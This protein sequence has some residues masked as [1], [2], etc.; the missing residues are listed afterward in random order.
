MAL[1]DRLNKLRTEQNFT[2]KEVARRIGVSQPTINNWEKGHTVPHA[3]QLEKLA[4]LYK[5]T[6][7]YLMYGRSRNTLRHIMW[8]V[9]LLSWVQAG[10][11]TEADM[12]F[13][14]N[15]TIHVKNKPSE[16]TFA[17][18]VKG[19][20]MS[21]RF[22]EGDVLIVE[23]EKEPKNGSLV[24]ARYNEQATFKKL[25][26]DAGMYFLKPLNKQYE[27]LKVDDN[28]IVILGVVVDAYFGSFKS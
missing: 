27:T 14:E 26:I 23:P 24:V 3:E 12:E 16:K 11:W 9:P 10:E 18:R 1:K 7:M 22:L 25:G 4:T 20:S 5:T 15:E 19:D 28:E 6:S 17:V 8:E 21:P 13:I 2:M